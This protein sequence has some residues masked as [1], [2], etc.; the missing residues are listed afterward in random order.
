MGF[1]INKRKSRI[2]WIGNCKIR[3]QKRNLELGEVEEYLFRA[4]I[5]NRCCADNLFIY[6]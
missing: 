6:T 1:E 2:L 3:K 4:L 5:I